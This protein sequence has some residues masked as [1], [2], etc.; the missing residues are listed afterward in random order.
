MTMTR[1]ILINSSLQMDCFTNDVWQLMG[2]VNE[3]KR[4]PIVE[5]VIP[6]L[7][8]FSCG[9]LQYHNIPAV[10]GPRQGSAH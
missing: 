9:H 3:I 10:H 6:F 1:A 7:F 4:T 8:Q 2:Q 5:K